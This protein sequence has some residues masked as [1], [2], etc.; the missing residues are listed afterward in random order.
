MAFLSSSSSISR[1]FIEGKFDDSIMEKMNLGLKKFSIPEIENDF[2]EVSA[3]WTP[4]ESPYKPDFDKFGFTF[5][6]YFLFNLRIDKKSIP[7]KLI[8]KHIVLETEK[9][10]K[11][12]GRSFISKNEKSEIKDFVIDNLTRIIPS[13]PNIYEVLWNYEENS[14]LLFTTQ[15]AA[16]ELFETIFLKSFDL[17]AI[18]L[19]PYTMVEKKSNLSDQQKDIIYNQTPLK[20]LS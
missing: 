20:Y 5:G 8:K 17:K 15:K 14:L 16:N 1:Y 12:S 6:T 18:R 13:V 3:G 11:K 10:L 4:F 9:R 19:F 2:S 7:V